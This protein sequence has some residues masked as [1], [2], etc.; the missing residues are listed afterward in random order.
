MFEQ[1]AVSR[2]ELKFPASHLSTMLSY[3]SDLR[4][5]N[6][7][8]IGMLCIRMLTINNRKHLWFRKVNYACSVLTE[9]AQERRPV[10]QIRQAQVFVHII[11]A[12][13]TQKSP[14]TYAQGRKLPT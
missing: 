3:P 2:V 5:V 9:Q 7:I 14:S 6:Y 1:R 8:Q 4:T 13:Y 10:A 11:Y 12:P